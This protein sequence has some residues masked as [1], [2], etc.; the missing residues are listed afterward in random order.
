MPLRAQAHRQHVVGEVGR[1]APGRGQRHVQADLRLVRDRLDPREAVGVGPDRVVDAGEVDV[2]PPAAVL[3]EVRQQERH[4]VHRERVLLRPGELVP[5]VRVRRRVDRL[6]DELVPGVRERPAGDAD[7]ADERVQQEERARDLPA[8]RG[9]RRRRCARCGCE[10]ACPRRPRHLATSSMT[11][12]ATP[13]SRSAKAKRVLGVE[14]LEG[15]LEGLERRRLARALRLQELLPVP[16]APHELAVVEVVLDQVV[17]DREQDRGLAARP[18]REPVVGVGGG[19]RQPH[20]EDDEL[21]ARSP[22]PP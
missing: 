21:R 20:V 10:G 19:V 5:L 13:D 9:C 11:A 3:Q 1:L 16:P 22:C 2:E 17:R 7:R 18:R 14:L 8:A 15:T 4:L 12:A 6:R